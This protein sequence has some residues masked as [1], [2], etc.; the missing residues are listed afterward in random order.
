MSFEENRW[1]IA[2]DNDMNCVISGKMHGLKHMTTRRIA[3]FLR[4][5]VGYS[6]SQRHELRVFEENAWTIAHDNE[7]N[8]VFF[9]ENRWA[10]AH[11]NDMKCVFFKE[12]S[13]SIAH[14]NDKK[15]VFFEKKCI[16]YSP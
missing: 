14:D 1:A 2:H 8:C 12:K 7:K 13:C 10:I 16:G 11:D 4:K 5:I 3:C 6:P 9:E 15:Y